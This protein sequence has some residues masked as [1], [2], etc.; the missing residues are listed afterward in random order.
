MPPYLWSMV[1]ADGLGSRLKPQ[2][3]VRFGREPWVFASLGARGSVRR[4]IGFGQ[5]PGLLAIWLF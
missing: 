5:G 4:L 3:L 1:G 2:G